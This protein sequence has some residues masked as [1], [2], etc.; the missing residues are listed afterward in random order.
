MNDRQATKS[1][2]WSLCFTKF[3]AL[4]CKFYCIEFNHFLF[5]RLN[6][7]ERSDVCSP[8]GYTHHHGYVQNESSREIDNNLIV[9]KSWDIA[10]APLKQIPMNLFIMYMA[11]FKL[12]E[13]SQAI[14]Q[15]LIYLIG[16]LIGIALALY[17][18]KSMGLLPTH[19]SDWLDFVEPPK[20]IEF[21]GGGISCFYLKLS[22]IPICPSDEIVQ[23]KLVEMN[24]SND[25]GKR[26]ENPWC[27]NDHINLEGNPINRYS[28]HCVQNLPLV[29]AED[30][31]LQN[32]LKPSEQKDDFEHL[33]PYPN[34]VPLKLN[35]G[36]HKMEDLSGKKI[37]INEMV[38]GRQ[39]HFD[40]TK[41]FASTCWSNF[42]LDPKMEPLTTESNGIFI[43][44]ITTTVINPDRSDGAKNNIENR[45]NQKS[46]SFTSGN[47]ASNAWSN[48][49]LYKPKEQTFRF[50]PDQKKLVI[51]HSN[52]DPIPSG[53]TRE[54]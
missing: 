50:D 4:C 37:A 14:M 5:Y 43:K 2:R 22:P 25:Q 51:E 35:T 19:P 46:F 1:N 24:E 54:L 17:K 7:T 41:G 40:P 15:K 12:I 42:E 49:F 28:A 18:C 6:K 32:L 13:G 47:L 53:K 31:I 23:I 27:D 39:V 26:V 16:N 36:G 21:S 3:V 20:R 45:I 11:A 52:Q 38:D 29:L 30:A 8:P 10:L 48:V 9:K 33:Q 44:H 34:V